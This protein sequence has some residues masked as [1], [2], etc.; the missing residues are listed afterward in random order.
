MIGFIGV[1]PAAPVYRFNFGSL[2]L[3]S[4][5]SLTAV[6]LGIFGIAEVVMLM[7]NKT[8]IAQDMKLAGGW[9]EGARDFVRHWHLVIR[10]ALTG[11]GAGLIPAVGG[12]A[13]AFLAYGQTVATAKDKSQFGKGDPRGVIG[14]ESANNSVECGDLIPTLLFGIPGGTPAALLL[15]A[16]LFYGLQPGPTMMTEH[17]DVVYNIVWS[18]AL[19]S[20]IGSIICFPL[21]RPLARLT[22]I[23]LQAMA[24]ILLL[25]MMLGAF[26]S[27]QSGGDLVMLLAMGLLGSTFRATGFPRAPFLIGFVLSQPLERYYFLTSNLYSFNDWIFRPIVDVILAILIAPIVVALV[28]MLLRRRHRNDVP[29]EPTSVLIDPAQI[30]P[31][32]AQTGIEDADAGGSLRAWP[33]VFALFLVVLF[34]GSLILGRSYPSEA[35]LAPQLVGAAGLVVSVL[36][37]ASLVRR[38][39]G[40]HD[41][42]FGL[43]LL[44]REWGPGATRALA[45]FGLI[46]GL[47]ILTHFVGFLFALIVFL[48]FFLW[49]VA[50][51]SVRQCVLESGIVIVGMILLA[52]YSSIAIPP[53]IWLNLPVSGV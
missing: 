49:R 33:V 23:P 15:G 38:R 20:V 24:P 42:R 7:M 11:I 10:G 21:S 6:A 43:H 30:D 5:V 26:Q 50:K 47:I 52:H 40:A 46:A 2:Y 13:G 19:A 1:A 44:R 28:R 41:E 17:L 36:L 34:G 3:S 39:R 35:R 51:V 12:S 48:P 9:M 37:L 8:M 14:P 45:G 25:I 29:E 4:G 22:K 16:L 27:F 53:G 32:L 31:A 18:F